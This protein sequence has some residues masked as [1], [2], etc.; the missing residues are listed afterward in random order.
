M[1]KKRVVKRFSSFIIILLLLQVFLPA[2]PTPVCADSEKIV[3]ILD[4]GHGGMDGGSDKGIRTEKEYNLILAQY[5]AE[6]LR[7]NGNFEVRLTREDDT[8]L[9]FL[10]RALYIREY[11]ADILISLHCNS[12]EDSSVKGNM[13]LVSVIDKF[14]AS[15]LAGK[16]LDAI[17]SAVD[18]NCGNVATREDTGDSLGVYYWNDE[19]Q[20]DMPGER[21]SGTVSDYFSINTWSSKFGTPSII[22]EHGYVSNAH[23]REILDSDENLKKIAYAEAQAVIDFYTGH[24][25]QWPSEKTVDYPSNCTLTGTKS[26]RCQICGM[27]SATESLPAAPDTHYWRQTASLAA[28]CT[29]DG[30]IE[31]ICQISDNLNSK[32]YPCEV[33]YYTATLPETGHNYQVIEDTQAGHGKDGHYIQKCLYCGD[34]IEEVRPGDPHQYEITANIPPTCTEDGGV[35]YA[36][37]VCGDSYTETIPAL[38]HDFEEIERVEISG[39]TNGYILYKCRTCGEEKR[40]IL[41]ACEHEYTNRIETPATCET[42][43]KISETCSK[44]GYVHEEI[45]PATGHTLTVMMDVPPTC[46]NEGYYRAEC[47]VCGAKFIENRPAIGHTYIIKEET[48]HIL[49]KV[50]QICGQEITEEITRRNLLSIFQ[51]PAAAIILCV[52]LIQLIAIPVIVVYHHRHQKKL[53]EIRRKT[54]TYYENEE[55]E[56]LH[57]QK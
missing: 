22:V 5:V 3:V 11:N 18:I 35:A 15:T 48:Q 39:D 20:W 49:T 33:H 16:I 4:A 44:C 6:A 41:S 24:T 52:I 43:G 19:Y 51:N 38:G 14:N 45:L 54:E 17:S 8:Y 47:S 25:H 32:G 12:N 31:Y 42:N 55:K 1:F 34:V 7:A 9:Q 27:K 26:Y 21:S 29:E 50:C 2:L 10:E 30:Y 23:D 28:T 36:C 53:S 40:E 46:E 56:E 57:S 13:A 37:T